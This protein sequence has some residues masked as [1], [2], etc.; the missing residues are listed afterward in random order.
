MTSNA[1]IERQFGKLGILRRISWIRRTDDVVRSA[2]TRRRA[3]AATGP[4]LDSSTAAI[5]P[6]FDP[7]VRAGLQHRTSQLLTV[8]MIRPTTASAAQMM[9]VFSKSSARPAI[10]AA[11]LS[12]SCRH[13]RCRRNEFYI[14][15]YRTCYHAAIGQVESYSVYNHLQRFTFAKCVSRSYTPP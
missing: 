2:E 5:A 13:R 6:S 15:L 9:T 12:E 7:L 3:W 14:C 10:H 8:A 4:I 1:F 11:Y